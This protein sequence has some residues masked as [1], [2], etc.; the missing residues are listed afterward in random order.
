MSHSPL[1][2]F[3]NFYF[4]PLGAAYGSFF[5]VSGRNVAPKRK[6]GPIVFP[7]PSPRTRPP[8]VKISMILIDR[9]AS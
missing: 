2:A 3:E 9:G 4:E 7:R 8:K 1:F 6:S 5:Y